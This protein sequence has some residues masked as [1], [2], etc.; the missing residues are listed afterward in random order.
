[1]REFETCEPRCVRIDVLREREHLK[2][3]AKHFGMQKC[4]ER[5]FGFGRIR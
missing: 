5:A 4:L 1:M 3:A 2:G